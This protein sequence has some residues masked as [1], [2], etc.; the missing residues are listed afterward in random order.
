MSKP[1][2]AAVALGKKRA[3]TLTTAHQQAAAQAKAAKLTKEER[4]AMMSRVVS[5]RWAKHK[6]RKKRS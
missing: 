6:K 2:P 3:K 5:A 1:N 4:S